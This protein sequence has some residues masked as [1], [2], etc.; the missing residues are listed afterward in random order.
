MAIK[1]Y[2]SG[3]NT[4]CINKPLCFLT[5]VRREHLTDEDV[6]KNKVGSIL[7][8]VLSTDEH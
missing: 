5:I 2:Q 3:I 7:K 6:I 8:Q 1:L 4:F